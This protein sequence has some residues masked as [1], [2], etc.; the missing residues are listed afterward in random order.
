MLHSTT[1]LSASANFTKRRQYLRI[2]YT[3]CNCQ[4]RNGTYPRDC[5]CPW[6]LHFGDVMEN[7]YHYDE[8]TRTCVMPARELNCNAFD[9]QATCEQKCNMTMH[10]PWRKRKSRRKTKSI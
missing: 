7:M 6:D 3:G 1:D 2:K 8:L 5:L 10:S 4:F 9:S